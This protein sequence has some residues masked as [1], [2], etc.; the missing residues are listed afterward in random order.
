MHHHSYA[1]QDCGNKLLSKLCPDSSIASKISCG[2]TKATSYTVFVFVQKFKFILMKMHKNCCH[3]SRDLLARICTK[4]FVSS[5]GFAPDPTGGAYSAPQTPNW[6]RG[7]APGKG[8]EGGEG[9][10]RDGRDARVGEGEGRESRNA[11]IQ[12]WQA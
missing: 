10:M 11:Q 4:S 7:W 12:S 6:F 1:S 8:K 9:E 3:Q 2:C 5:W